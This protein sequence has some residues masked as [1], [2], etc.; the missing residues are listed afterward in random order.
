MC[1]TAASEDNRTGQVEDEHSLEKETA[2]NKDSECFV[3]PEKDERS[4]KDQSVAEAAIN[5]CR[6]NDDEE[7]KY[8]HGFIL[9]ILT[10]AL[11]AAVFMV[12]L[13]NSI[14]CLT[15]LPPLL[16]MSPP[17]LNRL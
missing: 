4:A 2:P 15:P 1:A 6:V 13:D 11:M 12:A 7:D 17:F 16:N 8:L 9:K 5:T 14:I 3:E 10:L